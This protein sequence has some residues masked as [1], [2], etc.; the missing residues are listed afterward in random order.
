MTRLS[1]GLLTL[2]LIFQSVWSD[3]NERYLQVAEIEDWANLIRHLIGLGFVLLVT[4]SIVYDDLATHI[5]LKN[6][7]K[8]ER[9]AGK[10]VSCEEMKD[11]VKKYEIQ[12]VYAATS[13]KC[14]YRYIHQDTTGP[15]STSTSSP[16]ALLQKQ[17]VRRFESNWMT[18]R[19]SSIDLFLI[20]SLPRSACTPE[21]I[22]VHVQQG[23]KRKRRMTLVFLPAMT[24][25]SIFLGLSI[26]EILNLP[27]PRH[28]LVG[29]IVLLGC[30][31]LF[32]CLSWSFCDYHF[33]QS[34]RATFMAAVP[35]KQTIM[36]PSENT[37]AEDVV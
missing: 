2:S 1:L 13:P 31:V 30:F 6:Y 22:D 24:M 32:V 11:Q 14:A 16:H 29:W 3:G 33:Q 21:L 15:I 8:A 36:K 12:V 7:A 23:S 37:A 20:P 18:P 28:R 5:F 9:I 4:F 27:E 19:G 35:V 34:A 10:V 26:L 17:Y 25:I